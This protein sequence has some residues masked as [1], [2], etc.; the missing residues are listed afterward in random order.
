MLTFS[1]DPNY[2][3][4]EIAD[5]NRDPLPDLVRDNLQPLQQIVAWAREYLCNPH[6]QLGRKGHICPFV[7]MSMEKALFFLAVFRGEQI[8][9][10]HVH[11]VVLTYRDWFLALEPRSGGDA[12]YKTILILFPDVSVEDAPKIIDVMQASLKLEFVPHGIMV[13]QF[14]PGPPQNPG[15][16][17]PDF[18]PLFSPIPLLVIRNMVPT[19]FPFLKAN[20][21]FM[22]AYLKVAGRQVPRY[23][24]QSVKETALQFGLDC[25]ELE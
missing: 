9:E 15:L 2:A 14:H 24:K 17:N 7:Q 5:F 3:L 25:A 13:G 21:Q 22:T 10:Q 4:I 11:D 20:K 8:D 16:W 19:D 23:L 18:R 6:E 12:Q 1:A